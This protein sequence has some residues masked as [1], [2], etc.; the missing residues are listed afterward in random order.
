MPGLLSFVALDWNG[1][2]RCWKLMIIPLFIV[3]N[4]WLTDFN[5]TVVVR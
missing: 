5:E 1:G 3:N 2:M 4:T